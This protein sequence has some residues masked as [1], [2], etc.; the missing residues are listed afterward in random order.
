MPNR[1]KRPWAGVR[2]PEP[3][4]IVLDARPSEVRAWLGDDVLPSGG[5]DRACFLVQLLYTARGRTARGCRVDRRCGCGRC[6]RDYASVRGVPGE[7]PAASTV[8]G[9]RFR[10]TRSNVLVGCQQVPLAEARAVCDASD[11][12]VR[13][14]V[15][16]RAEEDM[17]KLPSADVLLYPD[18]GVLVNGYSVTRRE[19]L[20]VKRALAAVPTNVVP[21]S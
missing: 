14:P 6:R 12:M 9:Y 5:D 3:K 16:R 21:C 20:R 19:V 8:G 17:S 2:D 18:G 11:R 4:L 13:R 15:G 1:P 10:V 7:W